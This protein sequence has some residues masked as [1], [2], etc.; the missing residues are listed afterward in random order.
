MTEQL[1]IL[2]VDDAPPD[3][4][5]A[6]RELKRAGLAFAHRL[7]ETEPAMRDE[8]ARFV[9]DVILSD[10]TLPHFNGMSA[11]AVAREIAPD[12][13]FIFVS[14]TV[15]EEAAI[16][17]L[18]E[19]ASDYV[20]K[21]NLKRLPAAVERSV[22]EARERTARRRAEAA[23]ETTR[24]LL[25]N[26]F[27]S[28]QDVLWSIAVPDE[29][30]LF[31]SSAATAVYGRPPQQFQ[32]D[33]S[34]WL[35]VIHD[36]DRERVA[37][38]WRQVCDGTPYDV[39]Y[40]IVRPDGAVRLVNHRARRVTR[41]DGG[42]ARVDGMVRDITEAMEGRRRL[43]RLS[44]IREVLGKI[45]AAIVRIR[46]RQALCEEVCRVAVEVGGLPVAWIGRV[47]PATQ[48]IVP[49]AH[50]GTPAASMLMGLRL[51]ARADVPEGQGLAGI[52]VRTKDVAIAN[53]IANDP[54]VTNRQNALAHGSRSLA[55]LPLIVEDVAYGILS[56]HSA[57]PGFF[58]QEE[59]GLLREVAGNVAFALELVAKQERVEYLALYDPLTGLPNRAL[60]QD[61]LRRMVDAA[62]RART[63][64]A[65]MLL[66]VERFKEVNDTFGQL[67]GDELL[68]MVAG[69]L[70]AAAKDDW[71]VARLAGDQF[72]LVVADAHDE[73]TVGNL[74]ERRIQ[75][76]CDAPYTLEGRELRVPIRAG[77][78]L[79][80]N[81]ADSA[82]TLFQAAEAAIKQAKQSRSRYLFY[83]PRLNARVNERLLLETRL[84][85]GLAE[86]QFVLYFQP[87]IDL[88]TRQIRGVEALLRWNDPQAGLVPP[89]RFIRVLEETGLILEVGQ[90]LIEEAVATHRRWRSMGLPT[91]RIAVNVAPLQLQQDG[92]I[93]DLAGALRANGPGESGLDLEITE[94]L[95][96]ED[97]E[98][99][100]RK[101]KAV[102]ELGVQVAL[103]DFG[104]GYS[105]LSYLSKLPIDMLK[106]DR[107]FIAGVTENPHDTSIVN[108]II[109]LAQSLRLRVVAE[110]VE[111]EE[112]A[113]L[114]RLLRCD[115]MQGY[116]FSPPVPPTAIE[117]MLR[118]GRA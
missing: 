93:A 3:V 7:V 19:G 44:R 82:E 65:L 118:D 108:A 31:V 43:A 52:A 40:R 110:G 66:D 35:R 30:V 99:T 114:L 39:E 38:A 12:T 6:L 83:S 111:T 58:D 87:R 115:E 42:P 103:D 105:S 32:A 102:Q 74:I 45:N 50:Y 56:I 29:Q 78:A 73:A 14:G 18:K 95:V 46:E 5:L 94:G 61:R 107:S 59:V 9:P 57:E 79:F 112:Q 104:T 28:L 71:G 51:S 55:C 24:G 37:A 47:D 89:G 22:Q 69:R 21:G 88:V 15:G 20:L 10:F 62:Q 116:L 84:R 91:A 26:I 70:R 1:K 90:W 25:R 75:E 17:V 16:R 23:L 63:K 11:L 101:L 68:R 13:P 34:L 76:L 8:L 4:E 33:P 97:A 64:L 117:A 81:D 109:S 92:F 67:A 41:G 27:D 54:G 2:V 86:Q 53:D 77:V 113:H 85:R 36:E 98:G 60:L 48:D 80:P 96:M 72:A 100:I 49:I 106:I